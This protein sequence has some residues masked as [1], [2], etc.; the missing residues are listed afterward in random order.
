MSETAACKIVRSDETS[1][2]PDDQAGIVLLSE[3]DS[4]VP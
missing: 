4:I 2:G 3:L 1:S